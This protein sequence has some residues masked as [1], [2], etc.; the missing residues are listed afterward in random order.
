MPNEF[1][2]EETK[3]IES[4]LDL[5]CHDCKRDCEECRISELYKYLNE[6]GTVKEEKD[7]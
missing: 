1:N 4:F 5:F 6:M 3:V 7:E 2:E